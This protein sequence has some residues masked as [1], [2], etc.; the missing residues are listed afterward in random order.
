[1]R[2]LIIGCGYIG[3]AAAHALVQ[4]GDSVTGICR[5]EDSAS[6]LKQAGIHPV[7]ADVTEPGSFRT[8]PAS[9]DGVV[10]CV[11]SSR[12]GVAAYRD[13]Y[14]HGTTNLLKW[15]EQGSAKP[16]IF[17]GSTTVY[18][19]THGEWVDE[20]SP[21]EPP[22]ESG[23]ILLEAE[24]L[25]LDSALPVTILRLSAVY[26]PGRHAMLDKLREGTTVFP[27]HGQHYLNMAHRDDIVQAIVAALDR[28]PAGR[29]INIADD[30]PVLQ[31]DYV[32]W[33]CERLGLPMVKFDPNAEPRFK[34]GMRK[35]LQPNRRIRNVEMK[36]ALGVQLEFP[37]FRAGL[38]AM[39]QNPKS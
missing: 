34:G 39:I 3:T 32:R 31:A 2:V 25:L 16:I 35:G 38:S 37:N 28:K 14:L 1:M 33:L 30:E 36:S 10:Y 15:A 7:I 26:G 21:T 20:T 6:T 5:S 18:A 12:Q 23:K 22:H 11:S 19:Q 4:R 13:V 9:F 29:I 8:L 27:G 24:K 17:T